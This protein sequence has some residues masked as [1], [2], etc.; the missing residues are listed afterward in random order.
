[1][2]DSDN[3][4]YETRRNFSNLISQIF[5]NTDDE[6]D[7]KATIAAKTPPNIPKT[8]V[9]STLFGKA[10]QIDPLKLPDTQGT[11]QYATKLDQVEQNPDASPVFPVPLNIPK[12][13]PKNQVIKRGVQPKKKAIFSGNTQ[14]PLVATGMF[15][16]GHKP[17]EEL[18]FS[19]I[20]EKI[21]SH[22]QVWKKAEKEK[23]VRLNPVDLKKIPVPK[24]RLKEPEKLAN[25]GP[26][27]H[28]F[29]ERVCDIAENKEPQ[30]PVQ[31]LN[32]EIC[33]VFIN[34]PYQNPLSGKALRPQ[35]NL[36]N[37]FV[38]NCKPILAGKNIYRTPIQLKE[39]LKKDQAL[40]IDK[41]QQTSNDAA[42]CFTTAT[43]PAIKPEYSLQP[44]Q[45]EALAKMKDVLIK[46][47]E[48]LKNGKYGF[49]FKGCLFPHTTGS[50]KTL[51]LDVGAFCILALVA[52]FGLKGITIITPAKVKPQ[53]ENS[54]NL[55]F[56]EIQNQSGKNN[57]IKHLK[58]NGITSADDLSNIIT[59]ETYK[60]F[61]KGN[62]A[63]RAIMLDE[64]HEARNNP[65][66]SKKGK[67]GKQP[68]GGGF[69]LDQLREKYREKTEEEL[70]GLLKAQNLAF[71]NINRETM[72]DRLANWDELIS[73]YPYKD[74]A[75]M[76][77][78][79]MKTFLWM[80]GVEV[81][82]KK[83]KADLQELVSK[84]I[85]TPLRP[86]GNPEEYNSNSIAIKVSRACKEAAAV[87][88]FT[89]TPYATDF[90]NISAQMDLIFDDGSNG[91]FFQWLMSKNQNFTL[92]NFNS[93][94]ALA[95]K[96]YTRTNNLYND[97]YETIQSIIRHDLGNGPIAFF[98]SF[99]AT[100]NSGSPKV[101]E[102]LQSS[103]LHERL[104]SDVKKYK[105]IQIFE[106]FIKIPEMAQIVHYYSPPVGGNNWPRIKRSWIQ[107]VNIE[108]DQVSSKFES[109]SK[110]TFR[111]GLANKQL[112]NLEDVERE[113]LYLT[114][115]QNQNDNY[116]QLFN[117]IG[118]LNLS[119]E[120][121]SQNCFN[122]ASS[123]FESKSNP[124][125][126]GWLYPYVNSV[127]GEKLKSK[128]GIQG[129]PKRKNPAQGTSPQIPGKGGKQLAHS[130]HDEDD[131][132][133]DRFLSSLRTNLN[134]VA[135]GPNGKA[136]NLASKANA[137][138]AIALISPKFAASLIDMGSFVLYNFLA[139]FCPNTESNGYP[140][141]KSMSNNGSHVFKFIQEGFDHYN[142]EKMS[143][144]VNESDSY[145]VSKAKENP[146]LAN[147][148]NHLIRFAFKGEWSE[149]NNW[150]TQPKSNTL[151][152]SNT[153]YSFPMISWV[154]IYF[155][156]DFMVKNNFPKEHSDILYSLIVDFFQFFT[157][158]SI[159]GSALENAVNHARE[160]YNR[161]YALTLIFSKAAQTGVDLAGTN[162][163][164]IGDLQFTWLDTKQTIG[165]GGRYN[166]HSLRP[167]EFK[168]YRVI[169]PLAVRK[170]SEKQIIK[171]YSLVKGN[172]NP[173]LM[174]TVDALLLAISDGR[175]VETEI[176]EN[177]F[178]FWTQAY[179]QGYSLQNPSVPDQLPDN[180]D[181]FKTTPHFGTRPDVEIEN[182]AL[183][184]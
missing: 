46:R 96:W 43:P 131:P 87:F 17:D 40:Q 147:H 111:S 8:P 71:I 90:S 37:E 151:G 35:S 47:K 158:E 114:P 174:P 119:G 165:R 93:T 181:Q 106:A 12:M 76:G 62:F 163:L 49:P 134:I 27:K 176:F 10:T 91:T 33:E 42:Y 50:G 122:D 75:T 123:N 38:K 153:Q 94:L 15:L 155:I 92:D 138:K 53:I 103:T 70:A 13:R 184:I 117:S 128:A 150:L 45:I 98:N 169:V 51:L 144:D 7:I 145:W 161:G 36:Y 154:C 101:N 80:R 102:F 127:E 125:L 88:L 58:M 118:K 63:G 52:E 79:Y 78:D 173:N 74:L 160:T 77:D 124:E 26:D 140:F 168:F 9:S 44:H 83:K 136:Y 133:S 85:N 64:A 148:S 113:L 180:G 5:I 95:S 99:Y 157:V 18:D 170:D 86:V 105:L 81:K 137:G 177:I 152:G 135:A 107:E 11:V 172:A 164:I 156:L 23:G 129:S 28:E 6:D 100:L 19:K 167:E 60:S 97:Y 116:D 166:S 1:M 29:A 25:K 126:F 39:K 112:E 159:F 73:K 14:L 183:E 132:I 34:N 72:I 2:T 61:G 108:F 22:C 178:S 69:K 54:L 162:Y 48:S 66:S 182:Q 4:D 109:F 16:K 32:P 65:E 59:V 89:S 24:G 110:L 115:T 82:G 20:N 3:D 142:N 146:F 30:P 21:S 68:E 41:G 175:L 171:T 31:I 149:A 139:C 120:G 121:L 57:F 179:R 104:W 143:G 130:L 55:Y 141:V 84:N 67:K 56:K